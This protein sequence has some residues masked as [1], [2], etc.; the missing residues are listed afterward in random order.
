[1]DWGKITTHIW[2][3]AIP[4][5]E[6]W[7]TLL[8][9]QT[10]QRAN[11]I[12]SMVYDN[13]QKNISLDIVQCFEFPTLSCAKSPNKLHLEGKIRTNPWKTTGFPNI[14]WV[15]PFFYLWLMWIPYNPAR[16]K[17]APGAPGAPGRSTRLP[18]GDS[19]MHGRMSNLNLLQKT[20]GQWLHGQQDLGNLGN[21][22]I[23]WLVNPRF[24]PKWQTYLMVLVGC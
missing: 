1:M 19:A 5:W 23:F 12:L 22:G 18:D 4:H 13:P 17:W 24:K 21:L 8:R 11:S 7:K 9:W 16:T 3:C 10:Q 20:H 14:S 6:S 2:L 15:F